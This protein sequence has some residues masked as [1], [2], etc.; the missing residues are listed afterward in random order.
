M[1][2]VMGARTTTKKQGA[3]SRLR[4]PKTVSSRALN[5]RKQHKTVSMHMIRRVRSK[6]LHQQTGIEATVE[7]W[8]MEAGVD[9]KPEHPISRCHVDFFV[10]T[11]GGYKGTVIEVNG[12]FWHG[13]KSCIGKNL[14]REHMKRRRQDGRRYTFLR[15]AGYRLVII[16]EHEI[17]GDPTAAREKVLR[18]VGRQPACE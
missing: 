6:K 16:W 13:C 9:Y 15:N 18:Y 14:T 1:G 17:E 3:R 5:R 2:R 10:P 12:C 8:L 7:G 11:A 4:K